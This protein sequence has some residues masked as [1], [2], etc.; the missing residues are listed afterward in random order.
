MKSGTHIAGEAEC[1]RWA[2]LMAG[3]KMRIL[4]TEE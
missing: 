4:S 3:M 2:D 1:G